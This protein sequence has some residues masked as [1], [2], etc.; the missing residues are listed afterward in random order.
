MLTK[1]EEADLAAIKQYSSRVL[2]DDLTGHAADHVLRVVRL[3]QRIAV[4]ERC[5][6]FIVLAGAYLHDVLD[7]KL[8]AD[9]Q[10][11]RAN[12]TD[13]LQSLDLS[14]AVIR[15]ILLVIDNVS[16]S[17]E[18]VQGKKS[19]LT[20]ECQI[21]QDADRIDAL[22]AIGILRTAYYGGSK[23][24]AIFEKGQPDQA[25]T[26]KEDYRKPGGVINHFYV[27]LIKI[28]DRLNTTEAKR[29]GKARHDFLLTFLEQFHSE[30]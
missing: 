18:M 27:K 10:V 7:D 12:L 13:F 6:L 30:W 11:A 2:A 24:H 19:E 17:K 16:F 14:E 28:Y 3:A 5:R 22:G 4:T 1:R 8:V 23:G 21:V 20:I 25:I 29:I 15:H 9:E 26:S